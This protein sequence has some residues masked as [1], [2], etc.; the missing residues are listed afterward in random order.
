[1]DHIVDAVKSQICWPATMRVHSTNLKFVSSSGRWS[2]LYRLLKVAIMA[3]GKP[4]IQHKEV[5]PVCRMKVLLLK[6]GTD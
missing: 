6:I 1:M 4:R 2:A 5:D 3:S